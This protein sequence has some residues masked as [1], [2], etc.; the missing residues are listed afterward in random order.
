MFETSYIFK[1]PTQGL[2]IKKLGIGIASK[3]CQRDLPKMNGHLQ[4]PRELEY[5]TKLLF[6]GLYCVLYKI[7]FWGLSNPAG[8][9]D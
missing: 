1:T 6:I 4:N 9:P 2:V 3:L 5:R 8:L 7:L